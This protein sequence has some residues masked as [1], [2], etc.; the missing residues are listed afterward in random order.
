MHARKYIRMILVKAAA[1]LAL[2]GFLP[3]DYQARAADGPT[4]TEYHLKALFLFNFIKYVDWPAESFSTTS[5]PIV[6]GVL[7]RDNFQD[8]LPRVIE[9]KTVKGRTI[10]IRHITSDDEIAGCHIL[11]ISS[12]ENLRSG[13]TLR[14]TATMPVLTVG[15]Q[16]QFLQKG[17]I[18]NFTLKEGKV[19]L[20]ISLDAARLAK[21]QVSSKL[22]SVADIVRGKPN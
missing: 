10:I 7:G 4:I 2:I 14:K 6:I 11:F 22:L 8:D 5:S 16:E 13:E 3:C 15:E 12:S 21:L 9:G 20:E 1:I 19:R 18:I 17:G